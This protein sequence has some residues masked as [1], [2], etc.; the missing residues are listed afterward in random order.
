MRNYLK[1]IVAAVSLA[2][3]VLLG[4]AL[5]DLLA[6][7]DAPP[8]DFSSIPDYSGLPY[9]ELT[10]GAPEFT[11]EMLAEAV[12]S[13]E[14]YSP[15]DLLGRPQEACASVSLDL[16]PEGERESIGMI[17]PVGFSTVRYDDLIED[18]YLYNRCHIIGWQLTG[19]NANPKNLITG[20]RYMNVEGM[21]P[22]EN[23]IASYI[24]S[25]GNHVLYRVTPVYSGQ[26]LLCRGM[27]LEACSVEDE[28]E[29]L[30]F[31]VFV[32][33]VQPGIEIDYATGGSWRAPES[34]EPNPDDS[35]VPDNT[36]LDVSQPDADA[37]EAADA[38]YVLNRNSH[39]FHLPSCE[40]VSDMAEK[41]KIYSD[42]DRDSV[43]AQGY[44][45]CKGCNP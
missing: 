34:A 5:P 38:N 19:E 13:Y 25:T 31:H 6:S 22:F 28:G 42:A 12:R 40:S 21:L 32:Y 17:K 9:V 26:E 10:D 33:N 35:V 3:A 30:Q 23:R 36:A 8:V 37:P 41:N 4:I 24:R 44:V 39:K 11:E 2:G 16:M 29:G 45:P 18:K 27:Q 15:L 1:K 14:R 43:I 20:T 7:G